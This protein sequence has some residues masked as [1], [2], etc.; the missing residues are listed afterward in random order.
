MS[1]PLVS[2]QTKDKPVGSHSAATS[3][4]HQSTLEKRLAAAVRRQS[5]RPISHDCWA[6]GCCPLKTGRLGSR[7]TAATLELLG[8]LDRGRH[9]PGEREAGGTK[10]APLL[11]QSRRRRRSCLRGRLELAAVRAR[12]A[13]A[14]WYSVSEAKSWLKQAIGLEQLGTC[15]TCK[16]RPGLAPP[17][18]A[19]GL[20]PH[21]EAG[22]S[23]PPMRRG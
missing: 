3:A 11:A 8:R 17:A 20:H 16:L 10:G 2:H 4:K 22:R 13:A 6:G 12:A 18:A 14:D 5:L 1:A 19:D 21:G 7:L 9:Q 15:L 23:R